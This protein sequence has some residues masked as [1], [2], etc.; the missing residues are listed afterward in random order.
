MKYKYIV[1]EGMIGSGKTGL[2]RRLAEYFNTNVLLEQDKKNPFLERFYLNTANHALAS[3]LYFLLRRSESI[4]TIDREDEI[5]G[6]IIADFLLEKDSIFVPVALKDEETANEQLLYWQI[7]EKIMP[8]MP[9]PDLVIYLQMSDEAVKK[10]L[11]RD[12]ADTG[13]LKLFPE[14]YLNTLN[15]EYWKFFSSYENSPLLTINNDRMDFANDK[16]HFQ[17][18]IDTINNMQGTRYY[19][20]IRDN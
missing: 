17:L 3:E 1:I 14:G 2:A 20:D 9:V 12:P 10:R 5:D 13:R 18:L 4:A 6:C 8:V 11:Q 16:G 19:L 15:N 7:K